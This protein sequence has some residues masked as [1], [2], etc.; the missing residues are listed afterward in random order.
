MPLLTKQTLP[1]L[2]GI[3]PLLNNPRDPAASW[4][5]NPFGGEAFPETPPP[6]APGLLPEVDIRQFRNY[7]G[8]QAIAYEH[9][10][11]TRADGGGGCRLDAASG[12]KQWRQILAGPW[13]DAEMWTQPRGPLLQRA[14]VLR[15]EF[16]C[17]AGRRDPRITGMALSSPVFWVCR[18]R[19][20]WEGPSA[21]DA[22]SAGAVLPGALLA[23][24][25]GLRQRTPSVLLLRC[26]RAMDRACRW[27]YNVVAHRFQSRT[28]SI[29]PTPG[30]IEPH[31]PRQTAPCNARNSAACRPETW[32]DVAPSDTEEQRAEAL[33]QLSSHLVR[34][35]IP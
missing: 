14:A 31:N 1:I 15:P 29:Q 33:D 6:L 10:Q 17:A 34:Y 20:A 24:Q 19:R 22:Q 27:I 18:R 11:A 25:V 28:Y 13:L 23:V 16:L 12:G 3:V 30:H 2:Q 9:F 5:P 21:G 4:F 8:R 7:L 35:A 32:E 26:S